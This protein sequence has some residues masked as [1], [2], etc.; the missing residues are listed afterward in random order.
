MF[1]FLKRK[2]AAPEKRASGFTAEVMTMREAYVSG[3]RGI[4]ELTGTAQSAVSLWEQGIALA[5][6]EG[7]DLL[8]RQTLALAGRSLALSGEALFLIRDRLI[9]VA[10]HSLQTRDGVP[11]AYRITIP[12]VGGGRTV[13]ALA[14]EVLHVRI[15][16]DPAAPYYGQAPL[17]RA[18]ITSSLL[19]AVETALAD[20]FADAPL[21]SQI[22]PMPESANSNTEDLRRSFRGRR[23]SVLI[24]EGV[25]QA[26]ATGMHPDHGKKPDHLSPDLSRSMTKETMEAAR[27]AILMAFGVLPGMADPNTT[28]PLIRE[29]Q[30][31]LAQWTLQPIV[32]LMAEEASTKLSAQV[33]MDVMRPLQAFDAGGRARAASQVIDALAAAQEAGV[34]PATALRLVDWA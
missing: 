22:V 34:E 19:N 21:G 10:Q 25:P 12:E 9:P 14:G 6:V 31:H 27:G 11:T 32:A 3:S 5:D 7:T 4:A 18:S 13:T 17:K 15:A 20:V 33:T 23:G 1:G 24:V 30:R 16:A 2:Q 28:G 8:D 29:A 26:V